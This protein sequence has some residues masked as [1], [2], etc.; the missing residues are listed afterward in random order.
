MTDT[1]S[2]RSPIHSDTPE[3]VESAVRNATEQLQEILQ[4][5][6]IEATFADIAQ[7]GHSES[8]DDDGQRWAEVAWLVELEE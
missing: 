3:S 7:L 1:F 5:Q 4:S 6:G 2:A 8:W